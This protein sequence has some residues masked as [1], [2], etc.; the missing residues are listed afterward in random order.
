M[1]V[2]MKYV[3]VD[4]TRVSRIRMENDGEL[5]LRSWF[6]DSRIMPEYSLSYSP[7]S[8]GRAERLNQT[9]LENRVR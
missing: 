4:R 1:I 7:E 9:L 2:E 8:N 5:D 3:V 6:T